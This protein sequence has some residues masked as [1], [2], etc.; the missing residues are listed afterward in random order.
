MPN[1]TTDN[2]ME[3]HNNNRSAPQYNVHDIIIIS[4]NKK[5]HIYSDNPSW[6]TEHNTYLYSVDYGLGLASE[7][8]VL[9]TN[10][11]RIADDEGDRLIPL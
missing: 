4:G 10:I 9:E 8:Y 5:R 2:T 6:S 7:G 1:Q 11:L 3:N